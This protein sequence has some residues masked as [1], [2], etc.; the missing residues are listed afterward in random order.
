[1]G[2]P[3]L[4]SDMVAKTN[5]TEGMDTVLL[6]AE[7]FPRQDYLTLNSTVLLNNPVRYH[8]GESLL[9]SMRYFLD[10]IDLYEK[11]D[12][13]GFVHK[14]ISHPWYDAIKI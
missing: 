11:F 8:I 13:H 3:T 10:F 6:E 12:N 4:S 9:P 1:M 5:V 7:T 14:V 2:A